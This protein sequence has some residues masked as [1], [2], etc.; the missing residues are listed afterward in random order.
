MVTGSAVTAETN[1][2]GTKLELGQVE[3]DGRGKG[4]SS[5]GKKGAEGNHGALKG[6]IDIRVAFIYAILRKA[7]ET[8]KIATHRFQLDIR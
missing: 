3:G 7:V 8:T 2:T 4:P 1:K 6:R 5:E